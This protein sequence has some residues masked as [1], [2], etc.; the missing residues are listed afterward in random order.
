M[1]FNAIPFPFDNS[2]V[3]QQGEVLGNGGLGKTETF[4]YMLNVAFF[5]A[6]AGNNLDSDRVAKNL[7]YFRFIIKIPR[8]VEFLFF[9]YLPLNITEWFTIYWLMSELSIE[10]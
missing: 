5:H 4:P 6:K 7:E 10:T 9:H 1:N 8:F 3:F 2:L